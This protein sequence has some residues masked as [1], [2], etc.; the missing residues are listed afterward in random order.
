MGDK[1]L[2]VRVDEDTA[3]WREFEEFAE[4]YQNK[5]EAARAALRRG[6][7]LD[8]R[9]SG[10][11]ARGGG[12]DG[13]RFPLSGLLNSAS[14]AVWRSFLA[15]VLATVVVTLAPA[16][17]WALL[18]L[19]FSVGYLVVFTYRLGAL[20]TYF[21]ARGYTWRDMLRIGL[22]GSLPSTPRGGSLTGGRTETEG[23]GGG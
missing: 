17:S 18:P 6:L 11:S 16:E 13:G 5:S 12:G 23:S 20:R 9:R 1:L 19:A 7:E 8:G 3:L 21:A 15:A 14:N 10:T 4:D 22:A 2:S